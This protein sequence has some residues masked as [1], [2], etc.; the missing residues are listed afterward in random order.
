MAKY[1]PPLT[2]APARFGDALTHEAIAEGPAYA[3]SSRG[4][5]WH[6]VR[7]S[8]RHLREWDGQIHQVWTYWCGQAGYER[9]NAGIMLA[10]ERPAGEPSCGTC[11]GRAI[12]Y[13]SEHPEWIFT[14]WR[15]DRTEKCPGSGTR[16]G[17]DSKGSHW[18]DG[19]C[20]TCGEI[21]RFTWSHSR[22]GGSDWSVGPHAPGSALMEPCDF[23]GWRE[24]IRVDGVSVCKCQC[25]EKEV[26]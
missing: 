26:G 9:L 15:I 8:Y 24:I 23:H 13:D 22:Y 4:S 25:V 5:R 21:V 7:S 2:N 3:R 18:R 10:D 20:W 12:G 1:A 11:E 19:E 16:K 17:D 14:P 6:R